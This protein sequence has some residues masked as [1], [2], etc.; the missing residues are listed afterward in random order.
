MAKWKTVN[1]EV[2]QYEQL[3]QLAD[4]ESK[5]LGAT[6]GEAVDAYLGN[7]HS[8]GVDM[9]KLAGSVKWT[10]FR[11]ASMYRWLELTMPKEVIE[12]AQKEFD[13]KRG[14]S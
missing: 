14:K 9:E 8:D 10:N 6:L 12:Q 2:R 13:A 7:E 4:K 1:L 5:S 11:V 3:K